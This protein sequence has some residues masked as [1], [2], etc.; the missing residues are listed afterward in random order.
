MVRRE[1]RRYRR[2]YAQHFRSLLVHGLMHLCG[3]DHHTPA[4]AERWRQ[5]EEAITVQ[6]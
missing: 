3:F 2:T 1:Y 5:R 6:S 4:A